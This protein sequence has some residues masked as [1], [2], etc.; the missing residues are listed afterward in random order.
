MRS[1]SA[2]SRRRRVSPLA[3]NES[4]RLG[5][6]TAAI[7]VIIALYR[8]DIELALAAENAVRVRVPEV[9]AFHVS[10]RSRHR[11]SDNQWFAQLDID[12]GD[13]STA[14]VM[15]GMLTT[16]VEAHFRQRYENEVILDTRAKLGRSELARLPEPVRKH[17]NDF[18]EEYARKLARFYLGGARALQPGRVGPGKGSRR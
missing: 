10:V 9:N 6:V 2:T 15:R 7:R 8:E 14:V 5:R 3:Q 4:S 13:G 18:Y 12:V 11:A 16:L 17:D 1:G